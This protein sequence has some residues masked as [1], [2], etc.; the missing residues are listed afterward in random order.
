MIR[1]YW[2]YRTRLFAPLPRHIERVHGVPAGPFGLNGGLTVEY[3]DDQWRD[4]SELLKRITDF[5]ASHHWT[6][7]ID[8]GWSDWDIQ[9]H[10]H[11]WTHLRITS[12]QEDHG[13]GK[14]L[15]RVRYRVVPSD[16]SAVLAA[17]GLLAVVV[18]LVSLKLPGAIAAIFLLTGFAAV[19]RR[20]IKLAGLATNI[21][22]ELAREMGM[23]RVGASSESAVVELGH[24]P[25][26]PEQS[27]GSGPLHAR[28]QEHDEIAV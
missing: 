7:R 11:P 26:T 4:R 25:A 9:I 3:W 18:A 16:Y 19:W 1:S 20:G 13:S 2:R 8:S 28:Q 17:V 6:A 24:D 12:A 10:C 22:E 21:V 14:R 27:N 23:L 15:I 5:I